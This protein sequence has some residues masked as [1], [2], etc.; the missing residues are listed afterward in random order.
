[1]F[2]VVLPAFSINFASKALTR[3]LTGSNCFYM[4]AARAND[5]ALWCSQ[6]VL[7]YS[8]ALLFFSHLRIR[9]PD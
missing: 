5:N 9:I 1:M 4:S 3:G 8:S 7:F 2:F 6:S